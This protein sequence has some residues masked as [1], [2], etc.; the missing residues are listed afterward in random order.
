[1]TKLHSTIE[2]W[3]HYRAVRDLAQESFGNFLQ[4][5]RKARD[6]SVGTLSTLTRPRLRPSYIEAVEAGRRWPSERHARA[7]FH[8]M[9][10]V[11]K[12]Q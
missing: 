4:R 8:A 10:T 11:P 2:A 3:N 6:L 7:L 9:L 12:I 1:M 5:E